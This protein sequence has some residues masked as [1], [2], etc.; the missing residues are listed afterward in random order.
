MLLS[1]EQ[2]K[3][4]TV[5]ALR[6]FS[7][8]NG[9]SFSKLTAAQEAAFLN[10]GNRNALAATG[11]RLDFWT[12]S[13]TLSYTTLTNGKYELHVDGVLSTYQTAQKG[14]PVCVTLPNDG[15]AHRITLHLP[16]HGE[17]GGFSAIELSNGA[18]LKRHKFDRKL[19]FIGDSIT[20][21]WN[22]AIDTLSYAYLVSDALNAESVI[23]GTGGACFNAATLDKMDFTPDCVVIAYGTNDSNRDKS[24]DCREVAA[25]CKAFLEKAVSLFPHATINVIT[26]PWRTDMEVPKPYGSLRRVNETVAA[27]ARSLDLHVIDGLSMYPADARF[28]ADV[29]HPNALGFCVYAHNLLK[30]LKL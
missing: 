5:G 1:L 24:E 11:V 20:Q 8:E 18:T 6:I 29:L 26:P 13:P 22:T 2:I 3:S 28:M 23:Q 27:V 9:V 19:L 15:A 25:D 14:E 30:Q 10:I 12:D 17:A 7:L 16:S 4:V 21:G